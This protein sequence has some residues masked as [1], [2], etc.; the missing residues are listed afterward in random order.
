VK[1]FWRLD[2]AIAT[3]SV[4]RLKSSFEGLSLE[5][6]NIDLVQYPQETNTPSMDK[7]TIYNDLLETVKACSERGLYQSA[8]WF[9]VSST[10]ELIAG[11][12]KH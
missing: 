7:K 2:D 12:L 11:L 4:K 3:L 5:P 9:S 8:K 1:S 6:F 10:V